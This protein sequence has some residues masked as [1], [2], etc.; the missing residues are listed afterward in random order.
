[1]DNFRT[2]AGFVITLSIPVG[3]TEF[4][5]GVNMNNPNSFVTWECK[6]KTDYFWGHYYTDS[7]LKA[8][9]DL[10]QRAMDKILYLEQIEMENANKTPERKGNVDMEIRVME[11]EEQ[12]YTYRQS[13][14]LQG[15][16][17]SIG[18]LRGDF[19]SQG[20]EF[21]AT[22][23]DNMG[24]LK[25][26][27]FKA[28]FDQVINALRSEEYGIFTSRSGMS[29]YAGK[30]PDSAFLGNG[31]TEYGFRV[32]TEKNAYLIRCNPS[33]GDYDFYCFCYV[34]QWLDS[35]MEKARQ[36]IRFIDPD[37]N[38]LFRVPDGGKILITSGWGE[39]NERVC[40]FIDECHSEIGSNLYHICEFAERMQQNG[41]TYES[42]Q[43]ESQKI[44]NKER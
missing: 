7:L 30:F 20:N 4:V 19:G 39:K 17:G 2:N 6:D 12:K 31:G 28:E 15:Q 41:A 37:Y 25:T 42:V 21:H 13:M 44:K 10:C 14:Q 32:D 9:K 23:N 5:L 33:K 3:S 22:W 16:T 43:A 34:S 18:Y 29:A 36:G 27:E 40:R 35:H 24:Q 11:Q 8:T 26:E 1:M 38:E